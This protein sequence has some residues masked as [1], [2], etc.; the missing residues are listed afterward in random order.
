M[1]IFHRFSALKR[2]GWLKHFLMG[3]KDSFVMHSQYR[4]L[5]M[6]WWYKKPGHQQPLYWSICPAIF[7]YQCCTKMVFWN[8][9]SQI[10]VILTPVNHYLN[11]I[12]SKC[13]DTLDVAL[14][15]DSKCWCV[16]EYHVS[17]YRDPWPWDTCMYTCCSTARPHFTNSFA[18]TIQIRWK[19]NFTF[20]SI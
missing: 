4:D 17:W 12:V 1:C 3:D 19:F 10:P 20:T 13:F 9:K 5:L 8:Q 11:S 18:I 2:C 6:I 14:N 15:N 16:N 7:W